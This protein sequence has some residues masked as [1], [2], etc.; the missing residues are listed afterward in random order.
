MRGKQDLG[1][2]NRVQQAHAMVSRSS[3][4]MQSDR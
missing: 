1:W 3:L 2:Q 4:H